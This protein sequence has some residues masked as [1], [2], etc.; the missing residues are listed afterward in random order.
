MERPP[1]VFETLKL[2]R[3]ALTAGV[4]IIG[5]VAFFL[6]SRGSQEPVPD[7]VVTTLQ[8]AF[9]VVAIGCLLGVAG[10]RRYVSRTADPTRLFGLVLASWALGEAPALMGGV[11]YMLTGDPLTYIVGVA[12]L[13]ITF[14]V[15]HVPEQ[16]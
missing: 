9:S 11:T 5:F 4:L 7:D 15:V 10:L 6:T 12:I 16:A 2:I 13:L 14:L 1:V 8:L 3:V